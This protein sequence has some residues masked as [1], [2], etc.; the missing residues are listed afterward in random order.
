MGCW[1]YVCGMLVVCGG[2]LVVCVGCWLYVVG[3][4]LTVVVCV[5]CWLYVVLRLDFG[6]MFVCEVGG[7]W[8]DTGCVCGMS[9]V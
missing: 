7:L 6:C 8:W 3:Y 1:W 5:G 2:I 4:W 9:V